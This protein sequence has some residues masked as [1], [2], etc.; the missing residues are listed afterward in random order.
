MLVAD[1]VSQMI[2]RRLRRRNLGTIQETFN[3]MERDWA[4]IEAVDQA[5]RECP[6]Y[7]RHR[8][9]VSIQLWL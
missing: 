6:A 7:G 8:D 1:A 3:R 4:L 5:R 9:V 2:G